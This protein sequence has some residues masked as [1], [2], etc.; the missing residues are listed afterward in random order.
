[1]SATTAAPARASLASSIAIV[2]G[3]FFILGFFTWL[4]GPL[5]TFVQLAFDVSEISA[6][7]VLMVFYLSYFFLALPSSWIL[8]RTGMKRGL[9]LSLVVMAVGALAFGQFATWRIF[10]GALASLFV[11]GGGMALLQTSVNPYI[12][13]LGPIDTAA[14]RI[15][16]M[17]ICNKVAGI[18][19]PL[20]LGSLV[21]HGVG[22]LAAEVAQAAPAARDALLSDFA[23]SIRGFYRVMFAILLVAAFAVLFSPLPEVRAEEA[24]AVPPGAGGAARDSIFRFPHL[25]LGV[26][27]LFLYVGVE[28]MAGDAIGTYGVA[29]G[30]PLDQTK[31]FTSFTLFAMLVGYLAGLALIPRFVSQ[32]RYLSV[33]A[34]L[35]VLFCL[36]AL[37]THGYVS[38]GFVA[39]LGF[40]NAM[41][42]PAI[43]PLAIRGLG[44]FTQIGSALMVMGIAGGAII[45]QLFAVLKQH[46]DFQWVFAGLMVP[47]YLYILYYALRG[48]RAGLPEGR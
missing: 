9:A 21:L 14:R 2:G 26:V 15:A 38:V 6:F 46:Y 43:F 22:D 34:A 32:E 12:S 16:L 30:L 4:N 48:H 35:G 37:F 25:W 36:G 45:P 42:W 18:L 39:A 10:P 27:C 41:M 44:G 23:G 40:A 20:L 5:I 1:M 19:A 13:I 28:V 3:L 11:L 29:F 8:R 33:S 7:L 17:G 47:C 31:F 24:N